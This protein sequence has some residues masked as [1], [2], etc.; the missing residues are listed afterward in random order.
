MANGIKTGGRRAG[1]PNRSTAEVKQKLEGLGCDP[2]E[3]MA[4]IAMD[5]SQPIGLR[6]QMY[7]ELAQYVAPKRKALEYKGEMAGA[8]P[9]VFVIDIGPPP[10]NGTDSV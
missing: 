3:G 4:R 1:K 7:K 6:V 5:E 8:S 9:P 2:I 10:T